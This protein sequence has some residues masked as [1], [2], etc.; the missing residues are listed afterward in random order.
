MKR[1]T[2]CVSAAL[3]AYFV[4]A[5]AGGAA[6]FETWEDL[7]IPDERGVTSDKLLERPPASKP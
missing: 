7:L 1:V 5:A 6:G 4:Y 2:T 3:L